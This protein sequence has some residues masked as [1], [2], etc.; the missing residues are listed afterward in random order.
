MNYEKKHL[1]VDLSSILWTCLRAGK[2]SAGYTVQWQGKDKLVNTCEHGYEYAVNS[3]NTA[4]QDYN[5]TPKNMILV[6]EGMDSKRRRCGISPTYKSNR[7]GTKDS[8]APEEY[9]EFHKLKALV[10]QT[11]KDLGCSTATQDHAEGDDTLA[12]LVENLE[13]DVIVMTNDNDMIVLNGI[14][15]KGSIC[16]VRI[17]SEV[18]LNKY[19]DFDFKLVRL[20]KTLVGD[21]TDKIAGCPGFGPAKWVDLLKEYGQDGLYH[22]QDLIDQGKRDELASIAAENGGC[23]L[24]GR[25]VDQWTTVIVS[26]KLAALH[27]EWVNTLRMPLR[28]EA[29]MV[30][31]ATD[32]TRLSMWRQKKRLITADNY[33]SA[34]A[35]L[36]KTLVDVDEVSLDIETSTPDESDDWLAAMPKQGG[37]D[38]IGSVLTGFSLTFGSNDQF[39]YYVS[40]DHIDTKNVTMVQARQMMEA[41][42]QK[43]IV[44]HNS[45][46]E[47]CV[48]YEAKDE[49]GSLWRDHWMKYGHQGYFPNM[50]DTQL[51]SSY[52]NENIKLGLKLR[53]EVHLG[54]KQVDYATVTTF[55][56]KVYKGGNETGKG[57]QYKMRELPATVVFDYGCDDTICTAA[58][59]VYYDLMMQLDGHRHVYKKVEL[60]AAYQH[61]HNFNKGVTVSVAEIKKQ[62]AEDKIT[63]DAAWAEVSAYLRKNAWEGT[64]L[65]VYTP[66]ITVKEI[67]EAYRIVE[68]IEVAGTIQIEGEAGEDEEDVAVAKE[69]DEETVEEETKDRILSTRIRTPSKM[70]AL[71]ESEDHILF[72]GLLQELL[73]GKPERFNQLVA[74]KF[75]GHPKFKASNSQLCKLMYEIMGM[76]IRVRGRATAIM[77]AKGIREGNPKADNLAMLYAIRDCGE[78]PQE[79]EAEKA[80]AEELKTVLKSILLMKMVATRRSLYY[81]PYPYFVHWKTG[82]IH[83]SHIQC[84]TNTRR[85]SEAKPNKQQ[86]PKNAKIEG[87]KPKFRGVIR[88]HRRGAVVVSM[89]FVAQELRVIADYSQDA[90]MLACYVGDNLRDMHA[91]TGAGIAAKE[92]HDYMAKLIKETAGDMEPSE[93]EYVVFKALEHGIEEHAKIYRHYRGLGKKVNFTTE[94]GA[95]AEKLAETLLVSVKE[96]Q[97]YID[98]REAAFPRAKEWKQEVIEEARRVGYVRTKEGAMRH[99]AELF[100]SDDHYISSKAERQGV[101]TKIQGSSAEM[102]KLAE[103]RMWKEQLFTKFDAVCYGPIHDEVVA[104]FMI[105]DLYK[106]IPI[107]HK[108]MVAQYADMQVPVLS[109]ISFGPDFLTQ[110]E[111]GE[112]PTKEAIDAGLQELAEMT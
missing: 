37:V 61:A 27:P 73:D 44:V 65:P 69:I 62:E 38:V 92:M 83:P 85:A 72:A 112:E 59:H 106:A 75:T 13:D 74:S 90:N 50:L 23:K 32:D 42:F 43:D 107:M 34:L 28:I 20:Y 14:N 81:T 88:P 30:K 79:T 24:L 67:K 1:L 77:R 93:A 19:G 5:L 55:D 96:A 109:S 48:L 78:L 17:N 41:C 39:T 87:H 9:T 95:Q 91:L 10:I 31:R 2:D 18:G 68:G 66:A 82:K 86:L 7:E 60:D 4:L 111:I 45:N 98:A 12:Y 80:H 54:Y 100:A 57:W 76:E 64:Q 58:L 47:L 49:D 8:R 35:H 105:E 63:F 26:G 56:T 33:D 110:I 36:K 15:S 6:V 99:L 16:M 40:V 94:Y 22:L 21:A 3:I 89:D 53:S 29:G 108:C 25:I 71:L 104:S 11:Y 101:N 84:G 102:T 46:F 103:G 97:Q 52:A 70:P 51:E